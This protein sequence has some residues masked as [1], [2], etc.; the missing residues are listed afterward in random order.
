MIEYP[1]MV[2]PNLKI[3]HG[4]KKIVKK[5]KGFTLVELIIV[6]AIL[7]VLVAILTPQFLKYVERSRN[8][9]DIANAREIGKAVEAYFADP[10]N[11]GTLKAP[12]VIFVELYRGDGE[13]H[14]VWRYNKDSDHLSNEEAVA[15]ALQETGMAEMNGSEFTKL[16]C[17]SKN[18]WDK[19]QVQVRVFDGGRVALYYEAKKGDKIVPEFREALGGVSNNDNPYGLTFK[20]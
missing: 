16:R 8:L 1:G 13:N 7:A 10:D 3:L 15:K 14:K 20:D 4:K 12:D 5:N 18:K 9:A 19:I 6:I 11:A 17:R 2:I